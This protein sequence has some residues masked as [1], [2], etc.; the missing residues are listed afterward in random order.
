[1]IETRSEDCQPLS[2]KVLIQFEARSSEHSL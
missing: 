2:R 1:M